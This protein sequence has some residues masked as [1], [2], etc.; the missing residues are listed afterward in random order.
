MREGIDDMNNRIGSVET[1]RN[2]GSWVS[3][4]TRHDT[5]VVDGNKWT[6]C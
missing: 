4:T 1:N 6:Y 5:E 3:R 2:A